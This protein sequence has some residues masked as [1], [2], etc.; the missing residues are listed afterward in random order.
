MAAQ[1]VM[2]KERQQR[3]IMRIG[4]VLCTTRSKEWADKTPD[5][6]LKDSSLQKAMW[7]LQFEDH[8]KTIQTWWTVSSHV[9]QIHAENRLHNI[10]YSRCNLCEW[11]N[12]SIR[13]FDDLRLRQSCVVVDF[14]TEEAL[15]FTRSTHSV[16]L[17][18]ASP[19]GRLEAPKCSRLRSPQVLTKLCPLSN[20]MKQRSCSIAATQRQRPI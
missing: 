10:R 6:T 5:R 20:C 8:F 18:A 4:N 19:F 9:R 7:F 16:K 11:H 14:G 3:T 17:L 2:T 13:T 12:S 15:F 1:A